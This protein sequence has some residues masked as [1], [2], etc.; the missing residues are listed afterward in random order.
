LTE[1]MTA[2]DRPICRAARG[3]RIAA[4]AVGCCLIITGI[5]YQCSG[6]MY[7]LKQYQGFETP[8]AQTALAY[9]RLAL[10]NIYDIFSIFCH[11]LLV[12]VIALIMNPEKVAPIFD[13]R[14]SA[15]KETGRGARRARI[16]AVIAGCGIIIGSVFYE[17]LNIA[18][19][20]DQTLNQQGPVFFVVFS[21]YALVTSLPS[22][23]III[24]AALMVNPEK[25]T[26]LTALSAWGAALKAS[27]ASHLSAFI[28]SFHEE[29]YA[30]GQEKV[31]DFAPEAR[32]VIVRVRRKNKERRQ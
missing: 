24:L 18:A 23:M 32:H 15:D 12:I 21:V 1:P 11:G 29:Q 7:T 28:S 8:D 13:R 9:A 16:A 3:I 27:A 20:M 22:G 25:D 14:E 6:L 19:M 30:A 17:C 31:S 5:V 26:P 10:S 4:V 2:N